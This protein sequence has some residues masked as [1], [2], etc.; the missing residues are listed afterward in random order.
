[1]DSIRMN[2]IYKNVP[3]EEIPWVRTSPPALLVQMIENGELE[4]CKVIDI[5][6]GV[7]TNSI[8]L[9]SKGFQVTGIDISQRAVDIAQENAKKDVDDGRF[10]EYPDACCNFMTRDMLGNVNDLKDQFEMALEWQVLHHIFPENRECYVKN[11]HSILKTSSRYLSVCFSEK[12]TKFGGSGKYRETQLGT[13]LYFSSEEELRVLFGQYFHII[14]LETIQIE[15]KR[16][17]NDVICV[18]MEK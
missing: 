17:P 6:C 3:L 9:V 14:R 4:P 16:G 13:V 15:G 10:L 5:G 11:V 1:M 7:G 12:N 2:D 8:F 18:L